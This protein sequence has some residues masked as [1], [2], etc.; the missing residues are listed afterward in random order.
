MSIE[1]A[2]ENT[3]RE[4]WRAVEGDFFYA[5]S[6]HVTKEGCI[7]IDVGGDVFVMPVHKW[8]RLA[9]ENRIKFCMHCGHEVRV[10]S[11]L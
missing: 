3:D 9:V 4:I 11:E 2:V 5:P 6:I 8:H 7:G 10:H 1:Q